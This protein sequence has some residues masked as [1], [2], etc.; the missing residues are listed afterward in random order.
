MLKNAGV[1]L[2]LLSGAGL[3]YTK[4]R[5]LTLRERNLRQLLQMIIYLKGSVRFGCASFPE[6]FK[7]TAGK[8]SGVYRE[9][10]REISAR[11]KSSQGQHA[12]GNLPA[13]CGRKT[14]GSQPIRRGTGISL[15]H[16][17]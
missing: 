7:E 8:L 11:M 3:G 2:I 13:V 1:F 5:E 10:L 9:F 17:I 12:G 6:A 14:E 16:A 15:K 4:S